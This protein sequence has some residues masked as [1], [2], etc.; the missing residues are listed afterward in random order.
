MKCDDNAT[1]ITRY[2]FRNIGDKKLFMSE[3]GKLGSVIGIYQKEQG[4]FAD[5]IDFANSDDVLGHSGVII[6]AIY[7]NGVELGTLDYIP[8]FYF[9]DFEK[10]LGEL[11]TEVIES[12]TNMWTFA[13]KT[14][15]RKMR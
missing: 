9:E 4:K 8:E 5:V 12:E 13:E 6:T 1:R 7:C 2:I 10:T 3:V 11:P 15:N 14:G